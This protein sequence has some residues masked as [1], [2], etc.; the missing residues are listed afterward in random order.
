MT[1]IP[2]ALTIHQLLGRIVYFHALHIA[3]EQRTDLPPQ[4]G[5]LCCNHHTAPGRRSAAEV[6]TDL[7]WNA[8][9]EVAT[10]LPDHHRPCPSA[11]GNC[12]A[13]CRVTAAAA[14]VA[15]GWATTEHHAYRHG[16]PPAQLVTDCRNAA[17]DRIAQVFAAQHNAICPALDN[18]PAPAPHELPSADTLPLTGELLALWADPAATTRNPVAS[19][20]N[21][22]TGLADV[23]RV[24]E[25]RRGTT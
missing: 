21:H 5:P 13:T 6:L 8:L 9:I 17:A 23:R 25:S 22:C 4:P 15:G 20:L 24:L 14:A 12:C 2:D 10:A 1:A 3:P 18:F 11:S 16:E 19:W 7:A